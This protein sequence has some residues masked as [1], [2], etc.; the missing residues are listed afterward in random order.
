LI[1]SEKSDVARLRRLIH[2]AT[3][4]SQMPGLLPFEMGEK[5]IVK[6]K[7]RVIALL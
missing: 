7:L 3:L 4:K 1:C 2:R 5:P 6:V